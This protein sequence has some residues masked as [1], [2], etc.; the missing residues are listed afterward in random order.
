[1]APGSTTASPLP[2]SEFQILLALADSVPRVGSAI[3]DEIAERT[4]GDVVLGPGTLYTSVKRMLAAGLIAEVH[5]GSDRVRAY[6]MTAAG[7]MAA[8]AEARRL[9][10]LVADAREKRLLRP[11]RPA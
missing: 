1:M 8:A 3:K 9:E 2:A 5:D 6:R 11:L 7:R 10:R 4:G